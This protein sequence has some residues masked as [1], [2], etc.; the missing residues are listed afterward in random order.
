MKC[1]TASKLERKIEIVRPVNKS[2]GAARDAWYETWED[3]LNAKLLYRV[4]KSFNQIQF[5]RLWGFTRWD[6]LQ[7]KTKLSKR[8][9]AQFFKR[10][11][12]LGALY[13]ERGRYDHA[14]KKR[15]HN[16]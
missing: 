9:V 12:Q 16:R 7:H 13:V 15:K 5:N 4:K 8:T 11:E 1:V 3:H 6:T 2:Y 14:K 10:A